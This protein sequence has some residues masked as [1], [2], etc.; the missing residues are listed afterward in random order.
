M[1]LTLKSKCDK[2]WHPIRD[3]TPRVSAFWTMGQMEVKRSMLN[4]VAAQ[5]RQLSIETRD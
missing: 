4:V 3:S 2:I 1:L 5:L